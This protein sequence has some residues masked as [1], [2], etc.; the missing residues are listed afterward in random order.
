MVAGPSPR[1]RARISKMTLA[2]SAPSA[3]LRHDV[4]SPLQQCLQV[5]KGIARSAPGEN[6]LVRDRAGDLRP[7]HGRPGRD[8]GPPCT[9]SAA[10]AQASAEMGPA[11]AE[12]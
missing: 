2:C 6:Y 4:A 12:T 10:P 5:G 3:E 7:L 1:T 9:P 11:S 8:D